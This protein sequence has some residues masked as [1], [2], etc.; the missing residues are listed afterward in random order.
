MSERDLKQI[1]IIR[2]AEPICKEFK[3]KIGRNDI[4]QYLSGKVEPRQNK[5]YILA[6]ALDVNEAWLM[7]YDVPKERN[8]N[9]TEYSDK[10]SSFSAHE[11]NVITQYRAKPEMQPAVDT[12]LGVEPEPVPHSVH[13]SNT[14]FIAA[15]SGKKM[16]A[17]KPDVDTLIDIELNK[18]K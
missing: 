3:V 5:I 6:K 14:P 2:L 12:L 16:K 15:Q 13:L 7:G 8:V 11:I 4:S 10:V 18:K 1:D 17:P 9:Y